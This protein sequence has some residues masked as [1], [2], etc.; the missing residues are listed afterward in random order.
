MDCI[1]TVRNQLE[2]PVTSTAFTLSHSSPSARSTDAHDNTLRNPW[3]LSSGVVEMIRSRAEFYGRGVERYVMNVDQMSSEAQV[4]NSDYIVGIDEPS[5][6]TRHIR[7][8]TIVRHWYCSRSLSLSRSST[9][10]SRSSVMGYPSDRVK[11][12]RLAGM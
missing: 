10:A 8:W 6:A 5:R 11:P 12:R 2:D 7:R 9:L 1:I 3:W 4:W